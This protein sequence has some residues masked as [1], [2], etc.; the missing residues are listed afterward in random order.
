M[1]LHNALYTSLIMLIFY[2]E[3]KR[4]LKRSHS[5][6]HMHNYLQIALCKQQYG[7][8]PESQKLYGIIFMCEKDTKI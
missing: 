8:I 5:V 7:I 2:L 1:N 3:M 4:R 6:C